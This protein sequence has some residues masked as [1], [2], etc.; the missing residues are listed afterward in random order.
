ML[1]IPIVFAVGIEAGVPL[2]YLGISMTAALSSAQ[3]FLP[4]QPAPTAAASALGANIGMML[5][6]GLIVSVITAV[7]A[8]PL[9]TKLAQKYAPDAFQF[10][11]EI[12]SVGPVKEYDLN[13]TPNFG[14]SVL[15]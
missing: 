13:T 9:F 4:P 1:L 11:T 6:F 8:R 2:L 3:G 10:K 15:T 7:V 5:I 12:E 14:L